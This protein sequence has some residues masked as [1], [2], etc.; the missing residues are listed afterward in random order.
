[1][2][3][4]DEI[5]PECGSDLEEELIKPGSL[6]NS[7]WV[8]LM[9]FSKNCGFKSSKEASGDKMRREFIENENKLVADLNKFKEDINKER[10]FN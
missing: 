6:K 9:C 7:R 1:M 4:D 5:C 10:D 2:N 8:R 3:L